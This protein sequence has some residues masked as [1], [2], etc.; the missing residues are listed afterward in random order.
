MK[1]ST[2]APLNFKIRDFFEESIAGRGRGDGQLQCGT[3]RV[4]AIT[5][6]GFVGIMAGWGMGEE[7]LRM[8]HEEGQY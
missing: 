8:L 7:R 3:M 6:V 2:G 1:G 5:C 4:W